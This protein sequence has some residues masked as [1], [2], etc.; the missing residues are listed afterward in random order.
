MALQEEIGFVEDKLSDAE[1]SIEAGIS[2][3]A[4]RRAL[5][6]LRTTHQVLMAEVDELFSVLHAHQE[7]P[8]IAGVP[9][10][11][12]KKLIIA[13]ELKATSRSRTA[14]R[15]FELDKISQAAGGIDPALGVSS[16]HL[17]C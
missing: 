3:T 16:C 4:A 5:A 7:F 15:L 1:T 13:H 10:Q 14:D 8:S 12:V 2:T 6:N 11:C 9:P 17:M